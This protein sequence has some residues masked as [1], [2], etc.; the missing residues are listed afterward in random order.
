MPLDDHLTMFKE[1]VVELK[2]LEV[3]YDEVNLALRLLCSL[4]PSYVTFKDI[5]LYSRDTPTINKVYDTL[6]SKENMRHLVS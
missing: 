5:I 4:S 6:L 3:K 1:I 2:T